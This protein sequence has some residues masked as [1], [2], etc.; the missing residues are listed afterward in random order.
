MYQPAMHS[1]RL[2]ANR[3][4]LFVLLPCSLIMYFIVLHR[5]SLSVQ[6]ISNAVA[7]RR[8]SNRFMWLLAEALAFETVRLPADQ[9]RSCSAAK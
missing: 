1:A 2:P 7:L 6:A 5:V 8:R 4:T 9:K 3:P